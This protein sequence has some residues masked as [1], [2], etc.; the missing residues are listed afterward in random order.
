MTTRDWI[1]VGWGVLAAGLYIWLYKQV[2]RSD[3]AIEANEALQSEMRSFNA[4]H[5]PYTDTGVIPLPP[6]DVDD[7][8]Y[9]AFMNDTPEPPP[10]VA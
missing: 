1:L 7:E 10:K 9:H 6:A 5:R 4:A 3:D 8:Y 2:K